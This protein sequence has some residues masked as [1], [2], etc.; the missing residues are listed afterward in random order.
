MPRLEQRQPDL[1]GVRP[2]P[3]HVQLAL[4][5][6]HRW[7][8]GQAGGWAVDG[9]SRALGAAHYGVPVALMA[10]GAILVLRPILPAVRPFRAG[11]LCLLIALT[12]G[13]AAGTLGLGPGGARV[14]WDAD[15]VRPR[16]GLVGEGLYWAISTLLGALGAHI[17]AIFLFVA[18]VL[19]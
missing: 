17:V 16:G 19:L 11:A 10:T 4:P 18:G 14:A 6:Y 9:L 3:A 8:G 13:L 1:I 7:G 5:H 12:L 15:W 2:R